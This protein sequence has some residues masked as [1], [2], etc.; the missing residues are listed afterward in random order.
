MKANEPGFQLNYFNEVFHKNGIKFIKEKK[1]NNQD[2]LLFIQEII[3]M[4]I[5]QI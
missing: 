3:I 2:I 1:L 5:N 4:I